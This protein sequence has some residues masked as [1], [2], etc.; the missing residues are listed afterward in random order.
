M[1]ELKKILI[2]GITLALVILPTLMVTQ[3]ELAELHKVMNQLYAQGVTLEELETYCGSNDVST[4]TKMLKE[5]Q[6]SGYF[7]NNKSTETTTT[8][9]ATT[10]P[11]ATAAPKPAHEHKYSTKLTIEPT[12]SEDG[13]L[14]YTC[15]CGDTYTEV[16]P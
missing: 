4:C 6:A 14:T 1:K 10:A 3:D 12:C 5:A 9:T 7:E 15:E 8:P 11:K 16:V 2:L 13:E